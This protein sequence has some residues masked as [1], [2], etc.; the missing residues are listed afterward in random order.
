MRDIEIDPFNKTAKYLTCL[1]LYLIITNSIFL[2]YYNYSN[3]IIA[4]IISQCLTLLEYISS[5]NNSIYYINLYTLILCLYNLLVILLYTINSIIIINSDNNINLFQMW[6]FVNNFIYLFIVI[7]QIYLFDNNE[8]KI[9]ETNQEV[10]REEQ[11][12]RQRE[13]Y[14]QSQRRDTNNSNNTNIFNKITIP[15]CVCFKHN[16]NKIEIE[17]QNHNTCPICQIKINP[18]NSNIKTGKQCKCQYH[19]DCFMEFKKNSSICA[20][21]RK[22]LN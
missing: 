20:L 1:F 7:F 8:Q 6:T 11:I 16:I 9:F 19:N 10:I 15:K 18:T 13:L 3:I 17:S 14:L 21:C 2:N 22:N 12:N 4:I 5:V